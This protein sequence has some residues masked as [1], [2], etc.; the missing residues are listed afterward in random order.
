MV[1]FIV[2]VLTFFLIAIQIGPVSAYAATESPYVRTAEIGTGLSR[3]TGN[4][5]QGNGQF[6]RLSLV[7]DKDHSWLFE[8]G[9]DH[10]FGETS[11][12]FG[13]S[14]GRNVAEAT[15]VSVGISSGTGDFL[16]PEYRLDCRVDQGVLKDRNLVLSAGYT[17][18]QSK[19]ENS[20][21]GFGIGAV[22]WLP[23]WVLESNYLYDMGNLGNTVST[24]WGLAG[25]WYLYKKTYLGAGINGGQVSYMLV[26]AGPQYALVDYDANGWN[27]GL[28]QWITSSAGINL[29]Y[30]HGSTSYYKIDGYTFSIFK[31]F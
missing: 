27:V 31:E 2:S 23:N 16:A 29:R 24:S 9:R 22:L 6:M 4:L 30:E 20:S 5:G 19:Q 17:R 10:R 15:N 8:T 26:G 21:D 1:K 18:I 3:H 7:K 12:G 28:Q 25:T 11:L 14:H 13:L